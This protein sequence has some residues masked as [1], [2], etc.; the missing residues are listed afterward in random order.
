M[1][2]EVVLF[3]ADGVMQS[4]HQVWRSTLAEQLGFSEDPGGF[5]ADVFDAEVP[6]V[7][8]QV[9]LTQALSNLLSQ[10]NCC[11]TLDETLLA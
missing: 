9:D 8:G 2:I 3:D 10:R 6:A 1:R 4:R 7:E 11:A 5:L